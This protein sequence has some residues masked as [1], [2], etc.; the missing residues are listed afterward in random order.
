[1]NSNEVDWDQARLGDVIPTVPGLCRE[2]AWDPKEPH[3]WGAYG[4][5]REPHEGD[6]P[7]VAQGTTGTVLAIWRDGGA[8]EVL[9]E[10]DW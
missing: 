9:D 2:V 5:T 3:V 7:H 6:P 8:F 10:S 4:C 1:M